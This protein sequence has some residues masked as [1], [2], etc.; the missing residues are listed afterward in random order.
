[1][2]N[3]VGFSLA[4]NRRSPKRPSE[5]RPSGVHSEEDAAGKRPRSLPPENE[6]MLVRG[7][8]SAHSRHDVTTRFLFCGFPVACDSVVRPFSRGSNRKRERM[9]RSFA[10]IVPPRDN[11]DCDR[12]LSQCENDSPTNFNPTP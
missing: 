10:V 4:R 8:K 2:P 12:A 5:P 9:Q 7:K 3:A 1:V 6:G 11:E